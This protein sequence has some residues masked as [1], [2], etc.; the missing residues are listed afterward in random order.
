MKQHF[1]KQSFLF[2]FFLPILSFSQNLCSVLEEILQNETKIEQYKGKEK[3][4]LWIGGNY[5]SLIE[6]PGALNSYVNITA[7]T[8]LVSTIFEDPDLKAAEA[9]Y[10][11][12]QKKIEA[13]LG[14]TYV[15][16]EHIKTTQGNEANIREM[17]YTQKGAKTQTL[18]IQYSKPPI[19]E[20]PKKSD[21][22]LPA[23]ILMIF[24]Q[25]GFYF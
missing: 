6:V 4:K 20:K 19:V 8:A 2:L 24:P 3:E 21:K 5:E 16:S 13:C 11:S 23:R 12:F 18:V 10:M 22:K 7:A 14:T 17:I 15:K 9:K 25:N 1:L